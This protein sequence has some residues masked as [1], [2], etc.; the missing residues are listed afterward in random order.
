MSMHPYLNIAVKAARLAGKIIIDG[1]LHPNSILVSKKPSTISVSLDLVTS[2]DKASEEA[3]IKTILKAYPDH[4][5]KAEESGEQT[6]GSPVT[7]IIDPLDGTLNFVHGFPFFAVSIGVLEND[8]IEHGVI[9]N[10]ISDELF[11]ASRGVGARL[12]NKRIRCSE[13]NNL[14]EAFLA[15]D[16]NLLLQ[17]QHKNTNLLPS[18]GLSRDLGSAALHLAFVAAGRL[19]GY[20]DFYLKPWDIAAGALLVREAGGYITDFK[21]QTNFLTNGQVVAANQKIQQKLLEIF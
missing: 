15:V 5:I 19:D 9:Y 18:S 21:G 7:W 20:C 2:I 1:V 8:K 16:T 3:I 10:P 17:I 4:N 14:K 11:T 12:N 6:K 13:N